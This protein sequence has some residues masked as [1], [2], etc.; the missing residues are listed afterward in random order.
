MSASSLWHDT[1][2]NIAEIF[3]GLAGWILIAPVAALV[4]RRLDWIAVIGRESGEFVDNTK[5]FFIDVATDK[6][7][8]LRIVHVT[9]LPEVARA[10]LDQG[11]EAMVYPS[12]RAIWFLMRCGSVV[13]DSIEWYQKWRRFFLI[14]ARLVQFWHGVGFKRIEFDKWR[15][16]APGKKILSS[17]WVLWP[18][19]AR[20]YLYGRAIRFDAVVCTSVFYRD[21]VFAKA[22]RSR[23]LPITGYPRNGFRNEHPLDWINAD[24]TARDK[25]EVC[26][27]GDRKLV[28]VAPTYRHTPGVPLGLDPGQ[29]TKLD[30]FCELHGFE[31]VF[32]FHPYERGGAAVAGRHLH[33]LNPHSDAYP[34]LPY[35]SCLITDY[36]SIYMDYLL[37][38]RPVY[39]LVPDFRQYVSGDREIQFDFESMTP[40]PKFENW[41]G[42]LGGILQGESAHW[43]QRRLNL[44]Q[45]AFDGHPQADSSI[46]LLGFMRDQGWIPAL[47]P[48]LGNGTR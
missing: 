46:L 48:T 39:F 45:L 36:S 27:S 18:R 2:T 32:K 43:Q 35:M 5:Y 22:F 13:V 23:H 47:H 37:L 29:I 38:D 8:G 16:E 3:S 11:F 30:E 26:R 7:N 12:L 31:F 24:I 14:R 1:K 19:M 10:V 15:N 21:N 40:G 17:R 9:G 28:F 25:L 34:L 41:D 42:L 20:R 6:T 4:P 44:C 33:V